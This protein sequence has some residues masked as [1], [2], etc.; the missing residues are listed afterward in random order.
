MRENSSV[1]L[2][3]RMRVRKKLRDEMRLVW[4]IAIQWGEL[5]VCVSHAARAKIPRSAGGWKGL[6]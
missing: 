3:M 4:A 5:V 2:L 6:R 1:R